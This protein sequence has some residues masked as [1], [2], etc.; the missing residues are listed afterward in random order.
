[1]KKL[2]FLLFAFPLL[3]FF[4]CSGNT[5]KAVAFNKELEIKQEGCPKC[6]VQFEECIKPYDKAYIDAVEKAADKRKEGT[7]TKEKYKQICDEVRLIKNKGE[8]A[9]ADEL[10]KCCL[11]ETRDNQNKQKENGEGSNTIM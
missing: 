8:R 5:K 11:D 2:L 9:C 6:L 7:I 1:M 4:A 10:K 3:I